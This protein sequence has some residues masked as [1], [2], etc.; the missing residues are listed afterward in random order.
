MFYRKHERVSFDS[1]D[2]QMTKQSHK[3]ECDIHTILKQYQR[4]GIITHVAAARPRFEDLPDAGDFQDAL[5]TLRIAEDAFAALPSKV[6]AHFDND[7]E[8]FLAAFSDR[9]QEAQLREFGLLRPLPPPAASEAPG[10]QSG[11]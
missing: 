7:P 5:E 6:R 9:A 3:A 8:R 1:G 11:G 10:G 2:V 4:T